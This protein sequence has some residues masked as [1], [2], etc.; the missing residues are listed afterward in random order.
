MA[1][2]AAALAV[3]TLP[4]DAGAT[5][6]ISGSGTFTRTSAITTSTQVTDDGSVILT[7][8]V[9]VTYTGI[10][11]GTTAAEQRVV[12]HPDGVITVTTLVT[13]TG[14]VDG[15]AGTAVF[16]GVGHASAATGAFTGQFTF[17][18][19]SGGLTNLRGQGT[20]EGVGGAGSYTVGIHFAP[21]P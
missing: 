12:I 6:P 19:G 11:D 9:T 13:F 21:A 5:A 1:L 7:Q 16:H 4:A 10:M 2:V 14:T 3:L 15:I 18:D 8:Q 20:I 17:I